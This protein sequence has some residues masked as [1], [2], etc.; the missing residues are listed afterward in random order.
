MLSFL[1]VEQTAGGFGERGGSGTGMAGGDV[2]RLERAIETKAALVKCAA[3]LVDVGLADFA[4]A[5][6]PRELC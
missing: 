4:V 3:L 2:Q 6:R 5:E 1:G